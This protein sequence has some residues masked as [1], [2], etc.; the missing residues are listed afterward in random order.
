MNTKLPVTPHNPSPILAFTRKQ[1]EISVDGLYTPLPL[2]PASKGHMAR[3]FGSQ[4]GGNYASKDGPSRYSTP[5][6]HDFNGDE[7]LDIVIGNNKGNYV[8]S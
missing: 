4:F 5:V 7:M 6:V 2:L 1:K 3:E 8:I